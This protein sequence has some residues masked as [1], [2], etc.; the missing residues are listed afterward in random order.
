[1]IESHTT[2]LTLYLLVQPY[3][4]IKHINLL[5]SSE[6]PRYNPAPRRGEAS[7]HDWRWRATASARPTGHRRR[8]RPVGKGRRRTG[9]TDKT[10]D[11]DVLATC[12]AVAPQNGIG[13]PRSSSSDGSTPLTP[14]CPMEVMDHIERT[15][16][17]STTHG[18]RE[19]H[20]RPSGDLGPRTLREQ[21]LRPP[22]EP[23]PR[24]RRKHDPRPQ[25]GHGPRDLL[26]RQRGRR[27]RDAIKPSGGAVQPG[28]G[29]GTGGRAAGRGRSRV[30]HDRRCGAARSSTRGRRPRSQTR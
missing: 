13:R 28:A 15:R 1:M 3:K 23:R 24:A 16:A 11:G 9:P 17:G 7:T 6:D 22:S 26:R 10:G 12:M 18:R 2:I 20:P 19:H 14:K 29:E 30:G 8:P 5:A 27:N 25:V 21:E 4:L